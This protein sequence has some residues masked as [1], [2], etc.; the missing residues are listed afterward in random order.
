MMEHHKMIFC[1]AL[2][3][4]VCNSASWG[5]TTALSG[6]AQT[7]QAKQDEGK[8]TAG[9]D[10]RKSSKYSDLAAKGE[11]AL[12]LSC[13]IVRLN[14]AAGKLSRSSCGDC[15]FGLIVHPNVALR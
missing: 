14:D 12:L 11:F 6:A 9:G 15:G 7:Q 1:A 4:L 8:Y 2:F 3:A 10:L 13:F 5:Q